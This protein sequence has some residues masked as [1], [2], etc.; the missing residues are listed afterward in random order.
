MALGKTALHYRRNRASYRKKLAKAADPNNPWSEKSER[1][2]RKKRES[3]R[4]RT[5]AKNN[6]QNINGKHY[7]HKTGKFIDPKKNMGQAEASRKVGSKRNKRRFGKSSRRMGK[8][9]K[10]IMR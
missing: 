5:K 8:A 6:G 7:D 2:K 1:R 9:I 4:E 10:K 3:G